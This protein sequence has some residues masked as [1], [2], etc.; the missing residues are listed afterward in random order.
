MHAMSGSQVEFNLD[1]LPNLNGLRVGV[2]DSFFFENLQAEVEQAVRNALEQMRQ[3][4]AVLSDVALPD[5][6]DVNAASR[7]IQMAEA[8]ALYVNYQDPGSFGKDVWANI[9]DGRQ[10]FGHEYVNSQRLRKIYRRQMNQIWQSCD[11][12]VTPTTAITAP[13]RDV[14]TV[15]LNGQ[16]EDIRLASTRLVRGWNYLG[17]PALSL[18]CGKD[19]LDLPIGIQ[20]IA[21]PNADARLL[22]VARTLERA[23][24]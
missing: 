21:A 10:I 11:V 6:K 3:L 1:A 19:S 18:P 24:T 13:L 20:L 8:A 5:F 14:A 23:W 2:P 7:V 22:Q 9:Q 4:G 16:T 15:E 17:E 12:I